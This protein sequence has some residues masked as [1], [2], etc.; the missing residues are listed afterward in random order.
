M[1]TSTALALE[2]DVGQPHNVLFVENLPE[3]TS[4]S[5]LAMLFQQFPGEPA[6]SGSQRLPAERTSHCAMR[7]HTQARCA[8]AGYKEARMV[9]T[10]AGIAFVDFENEV[11][12]Q[13]AAGAPHVHGRQIVSSLWPAV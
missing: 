7:P 13:R 11:Q 2:V 3:A 1:R 8:T 10:K 12:V 5:M 6:A 9:P 4:A